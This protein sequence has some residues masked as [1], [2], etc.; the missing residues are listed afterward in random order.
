MLGSE[1]TEWPSIGLDAF[2]ERT[3]D[4]KTLTRANLIA[5]A[6]MTHGSTLV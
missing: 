2:G 3:P 6:H 5:Y 4:T 1:R